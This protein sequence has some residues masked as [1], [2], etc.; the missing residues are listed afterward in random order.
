MYL[1]AWIAAWEARVAD[2]WRARVLEALGILLAITATHY[3]I[4][5]GSGQWTDPDSPYHHLLIAALWH[6]G[7][8]YDVSWLPW[9]VLGTHG[10]DH[11][12]L[13]H[14][15]LSPFAAIDD[16]ALRVDL[17]NAFAFALIP[18]GTCLALRCL[19][20]RYA[21]LW[22]LLMLAATTIPL[23][24]WS[25][26][27]AQNLAWLYV[28]FFI[29]ALAMRKRWAIF[30][31]PFLFMHSYHGAAMIAAPALMMVMVIAWR[32]RRFDLPLLAL[33]LLGGALA[34][35]TS[36]WY[37]QNIEFFLFQTI[38]MV[39]N[40]LGLDVGNEW[41]PVPWRQA[42][43]ILLPQLAAFAVV[44]V[45]AGDRL[46]RQRLASETVVVLGMTL[47]MVL[48]ALKH[49]RFIEYCPQLLIASAALI[50]RDCHETLRAKIRSLLVVVVALSAAALFTLNLLYL[51]RLHR[52]MFHYTFDRDAAVGRLLTTYAAPGSLIANVHWGEFPFL[53]YHAPT[54][55]FLTGLDPYYLVYRDQE[56]FLA[57][58]RLLGREPGPLPQVR[59]IFGADWAVIPRQQRYVVERLV[60]SGQAQ[61][62]LADSHQFVVY[63]GNDA[64]MP[65]KLRSAHDTLEWLPLT[66]FETTAG[67]GMTP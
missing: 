44:L 34:L 30:L 5:S 61:A 56:R 45:A 63:V 3:A 49:R 26:A 4:Y 43:M 6:D 22:A 51:D 66:H 29:V 59:E 2:D 39:G 53:V 16:I 65:E 33:P 20:V 48:F 40:P 10:T 36:P 14:L 64:T 62:V 24:R 15:L 32:E 18:A 19:R 47:F 12:W 58:M 54:L 21:P 13:W 31:V 46:W 50:A 41:S 25:M 55:R 42:T 7:P 37:P 9:T 27:R 11:H 28:I 1:G 60:R 17:V 35:V 52:S 23:Y 8:W 38:D 57:L 67:K